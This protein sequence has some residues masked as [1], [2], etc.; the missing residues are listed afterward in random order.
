M[1]IEQLEYNLSIIQ[2]QIC[3]MIEHPEQVTIKNVQQI[4]LPLVEINDNLINK[5]TKYSN[6]RIND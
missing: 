2:E 4:K 5:L 1:N 6:K 3:S